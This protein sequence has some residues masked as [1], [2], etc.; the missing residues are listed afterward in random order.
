MKKILT[1]LLILTLSVALEC[2]RL[3]SGVVPEHYQ[4]TLTPNL[5]DATFSGD[6]IIDVRLTKPSTMITLNSAEI[7]F[8]SATVESHGGTVAAKVTLDPDREQANIIE[9]KTIAA[10][11]ARLHIVYTGILNNQLRGFYLSETPK[12]RYA[13]TQ[14]EAT[15]ARRA[16][17]SFDEPALKRRL[18][19]RSSSTKAILPSRTRSSSPTLPVPATTNTR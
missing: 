7:K 6:E 19:S 13:V 5:Q 4:L 11:P 10:G 15:D 12:R 1:L 3:P 14:F 16:F 17:P 2:Q 18:T 9:P 8:T